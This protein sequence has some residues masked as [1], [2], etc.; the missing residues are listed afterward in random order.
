MLEGVPDS[1]AVPLNAWFAH[2]ARPLPWRAAE[3]SPWAVFVSEFMLQQT[4]VA[5]VV[6][7]WE[8]WMARWPTP[9]D[10]AASPPA[11][12]VRAWDRLGY[13]R[14]ALWLHEAASEMVER[15]DG[16]VPA[17][18]D[19][20]LALKGV[21]PYTARAVA[22]FAFGIRVPV[23]DTNT[24]RVIARAKLG[25]GEAGPPAPARDLGE[26]A[27]LLPADDAGARVFNAA[28]MELGAT[29]CTARSPRCE[30]CPIRDRCAWRL[31]GYPAYEGPRKRA[32]ARFEGSDRQLRGRVMRELRA[33][34]A[35]L[36]RDAFDGVDP[37]AAR[38]DRV[39][40]GLVADGLAVLDGD[41]YRLP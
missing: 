18:V 9:A 2:A 21:G 16:R 22:A 17:D 36:P 27:E 13:P 19:E 1:L 41:G 29:V 38:V 32:Q 5:R 31:A 12:A 15:H 11:E 37:D 24:R 20:L 30:D 34:H 40:D 4:Q 14:R 7:R 8:S 26:M 28:A 33:M 35:P 3:V 10:L 39:L 6:P 25:Q 23:V